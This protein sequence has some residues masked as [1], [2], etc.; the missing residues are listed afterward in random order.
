[1]KRKRGRDGS[2]RS[3]FSPPQLAATL[4]LATLLTDTATGNDTEGTNKMAAK[5]TEIKLKQYTSLKAAFK[6]LE[7]GELPKKTRFFMDGGSVFLEVPIK[8][9][10]GGDEDNHT[11]CETT[12]EDLLQFLLK[13]LE[14]KT[15]IET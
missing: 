3:R 13:R 1:M 11:F 10:E 4:H 6:A 2:W 15:K 14:L 7:A 9:E 5:K 12:V 8:T